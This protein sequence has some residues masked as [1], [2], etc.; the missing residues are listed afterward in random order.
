MCCIPCCNTNYDFMT[1]IVTVYKFSMDKNEKRVWIKEMPQQNLCLF[2]R[3][4]TCRTTFGFL[5]HT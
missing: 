2:T 4:M 1:K 5:Q 3:A